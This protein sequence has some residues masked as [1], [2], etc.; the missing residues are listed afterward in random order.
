MYKSLL[1]YNGESKQ[2]GYNK[3]KDKT[4]ERAQMAD[5]QT[6]DK[7]VQLSKTQEVQLQQE[8]SH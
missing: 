4:A 5:T 6:N 2:I 1:N 3:H 7:S 8:S